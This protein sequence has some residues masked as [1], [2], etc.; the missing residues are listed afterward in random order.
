MDVGRPIMRSC[1]HSFLPHVLTRDSTIVDFGVHKGEFAGDL[2]RG[3]SCRVFGA[4]PVPELYAQLPQHENFA[5]LP[6]AVG[7]RNGQVDINVFD[8]R[9]ASVVSKETENN[10]TT[11][12]VECVTLEEFL[13]RF[14][15]SFVDL[16]KIDI[17]GAEIGLFRGANDDT[18]QKIKQITIEFHD[19]LFPE[20]R[21]DVAEVMERLKA[22]GFWRINFSLDNTDVLF[23]NRNVLDLGRFEYAFLKYFVKYI[24]GFERVARQAWPRRVITL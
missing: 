9:C 5:A 21:R 24:K 14:N 10:V 4:E 12:S 19:F 17:E 18:L 22:L 13:S 20:T 15:L 7:E 3:F 6:V 23:I 8:S 1:G 2:I 11:V 16:L